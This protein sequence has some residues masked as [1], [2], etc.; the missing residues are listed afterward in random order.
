MTFNFFNTIHRYALFFVRA[1]RSWCVS[2]YNT[3]QNCVTTNCY[4]GLE[5]NAH[6]LVNFLRMCREKGYEFDITL[7]QS[8]SCESFF[9]LARSLSSTESTV[10]NF[11]MQ[12]FESR[13][14]RIEAKSNFMH[15]RQ[16]EFCFPR[17]KLKSNCT[18]KP[19]QL[20]NDSDIGSEI[21]RAKLDVA[22]QLEQ[23]GLDRNEISFGECIFIRRPKPKP[24]VACGSFEFVDVPESSDDSDQSE[25]EEIY[26]ASDL[27]DNVG[28]EINVKDSAAFNTRNTFQIRNQNGKVV[29]VKKSTFLWLL[30][31]ETEK[32]STD[33]IYRFQGSSNEEPL[34]LKLM[35]QIFAEVQIG[36]WIL[37]HSSNKWIVC[38]VYSFKYLTGT[39]KTYSRS[40]API[41][42]PEGT[43]ARGI[44]VLGSYFELMCIDNEY[45]LQLHNKSSKMC[46]KIESYVSHLQKPCFQPGLMFFETI[47]FDYINKLMS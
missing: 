42:L 2:E 3:I 31:S 6:S 23:L 45:I 1:W 9:R 10:V 39:N 28:A 19:C 22:C 17:Q 12:S 46:V 34:D 18:L 30:M 11:T 20:P 41:R 16:N 40:N 37:M 44:G 32:C 38:N 14:N 15:N 5:I 7:L 35:N 43:K 4:W 13:L 36:E 8:Q 25:D 24:D 27:F 21:E 33:R 47:S 29:R 26:N